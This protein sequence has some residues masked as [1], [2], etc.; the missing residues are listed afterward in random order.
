MKPLLDS[1]SMP[2]DCGITEDFLKDLFKQELPMAGAVTPQTVNYPSA[3]TDGSSPESDI[4]FVASTKARMRGLEREAQC[5]EKAFRD[6]CKRVHHW[7]Q[8]ESPLASQSP[9]PPQVRGTLKGVMLSSSERRVFADEGAVPRQPAGGETEAWMGAAASRLRRGA[10][11]RLSTTA[12]ERAQRTLDAEMH[13]EGKL[14]KG[15]EGALDS[16][17]PR[18][19]E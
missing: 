1:G 2:P 12:L 6:Y 17:G 4:E 11:R 9:P 8:A 5:L 15:S 16:D 18:W 7:P 14:Q 3:S 13:L 19:S 10:G